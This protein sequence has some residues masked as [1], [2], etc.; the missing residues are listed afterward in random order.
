MPGYEDATVRLTWPQLGVRLSRRVRGEYVLA[1]DDL[2]ASRHFSDGITRLGVYLPDWGPNYAIEGLDYDVPYRCLVPETID[3]LLMAG[4][5]VSCDY[6]AGNTMCLLV[7]CLATGQAAGL[8]AAL[9]ADRGV[10]PS[11]VDGG[12]LHRRLVEKG[13]RFLPRDPSVRVAWDNDK[14]PG[15]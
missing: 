13:A 6:V 11:G 15:S 5:C 8:A 3:G 2:V 10:S 12:D 1:N 7:P 4:R 14:E 9:A